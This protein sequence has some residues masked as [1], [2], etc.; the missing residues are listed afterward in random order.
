MQRETPGGA[1]R[2]AEALK[3]LLRQGGRE[4]VERLGRSFLEN[5]P[6]RLEGVRAALERGDL[7]AVDKELHELKTSV[8]MV[9]CTAMGSL[10]QEGVLA[11]RG[12]RAAELLRVLEALDREHLAARPFVAG[13]LEAC[14]R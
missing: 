1:A 4:L 11:A 9:G 3:R 12:G 10:C 8:L 13:F 7:E 6:G 2:D 14:A 5:T